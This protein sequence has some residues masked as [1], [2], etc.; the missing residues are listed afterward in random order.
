MPLNK[1]NFPPFSGSIKQSEWVKAWT[2]SLIVKARNKSSAVQWNSSQSFNCSVC[3]FTPTADVVPFSLEA[4]LAVLEGTLSG[5]NL[6][7]TS[8]SVSAFV[9]NIIS[10]L[11][12][13]IQKTVHYGQLSLQTISARTTPS[14]NSRRY[15]PSRSRITGAPLLLRRCFNWSSNLNEFSVVTSMSTSLSAYSSLKLA[16]LIFPLCS[17]SLPAIRPTTQYV[18]CHSWITIHFFQLHSVK[19]DYQQSNTLLD[20]LHYCYES[21]C[22]ECPYLSTQTPDSIRRKRWAWICDCWHKLRQSHLITLSLRISSL[23]PRQLLF[24]KELW[25]VLCSIPLRSSLSWKED[26]IVQQIPII[27]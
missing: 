22:L 15:R 4:L 3:I 12:S 26:H 7:I 19:I 16:I 14:F 8:A 20:L 18:Y 1:T 13:E 27:L 21:W 6:R 23:H 9:G 11:Y 25:S 24:Q 2:I 17:S 10:L 5:V